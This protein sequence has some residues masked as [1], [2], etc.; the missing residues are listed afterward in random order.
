MAFLVKY[1]QDAPHNCSECPC[2]VHITPKEVYCNARQKHFK[3]TDVV[4][5]ECCMIDC[6][7]MYVDEIELKTCKNCHHFLGYD[8]D[9]AAKH[10]VRSLPIEKCSDWEKSTWI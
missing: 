5:Q 2:S 3:V 6:D 10:H 9:C 8:E 4:P 7:W 1:E